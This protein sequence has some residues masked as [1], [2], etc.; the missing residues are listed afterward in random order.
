MSTIFTTPT[1][2]SNVT[3]FERYLRNPPESDTLLFSGPSGVGKF[4]FA[5]ELAARLSCRDLDH[6]LE[7]G[8]YC[9]SCY[10]AF[11]KNEDGSILHPDIY[12]V[13]PN[14]HGNHNKSVLQDVLA[15]ANQACV[16][17]SYKVFV[18][19][20]AEAFSPVSNDAILKRIED[21]YPNTVFVFCTQNESQVANTLLTRSKK[22]VFG[23]VPLSAI[24]D[25]LENEY[26]GSERFEIAT[27]V[28]DG[29]LTRARLFLE[30]EDAWD[31]R[32]KAIV[33][34][35]SLPRQGEFQLV[36]FFKRVPSDD[37][38]LF[39]ELVLGLLRDSFLIAHDLGGRV[40]NTDQAEH[41]EKTSE[42]L[43][44]KALSEIE[45]RLKD[46]KA[47]ESLPMIN[48]HHLLNEL[49][50]IKRLITQ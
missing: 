3:Y 44:D 28:A 14:E 46:L 30:N 7:E 24:R 45:D 29:S 39:F 19:D 22:F 47:H 27:Q 9:E 32:S 41:L 1:H 17:G 43:D 4:G 48:K 8:A 13:R 5:K 42:L 34:F 35:K 33:F 26:S 31:L 37:I 21:G 36:K 20:Q 10:K 23:K 12:L 38:D 50:Q 25:R 2:E 18:F 15:E 16:Y 11:H 49:L 6:P 40:L